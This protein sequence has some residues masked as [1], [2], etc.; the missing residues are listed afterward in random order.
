MN[1]SPTSRWYFLLLLPVW[2]ILFAGC[3]PGSS[4]AT[5]HTAAI[6]PTATPALSTATAVPE[7]NTPTPEPAPI[8]IAAVPNIRFEPGMYIAYDRKIPEANDTDTALGSH[9]FI[10]WRNIEDTPR[11][12]YNWGTIDGRLA[13]LAPGKQAIVRVVTRC[14]DTAEKNRDACAPLWTLRHNPVPVTLG[15]NSCTAPAQRMNYLDSPVQEGLFDFIAAFG[16]RYQNDPRIAVVE[17]GIGYGGE[18]IPYPATDS[19]CDHKEQQAAYEN[20]PEFTEKAW[21]QYHQD[22]ID[23]YVTAFGGKKPLLTI[24]NASF[25]EDYRDVVVKHAVDNGVGLLTTNLHS[26]FFNNRGSSNG[27]NLCYWG[28]ST[29]PG[30]SN[31]S[32]DAAA[33][34][35]THWTPLFVNAQSVLVGYEF[36]NRYDKSGRIPKEGEAF[37]RW[38]MLNGLDKRADYILPYNDADNTPGNVRY[39]EVWEFYNRYAGHTTSSTS[40]VWI[41]FRSSWEND[42]TWCPDIYDYSWYLVSELETLPYVE[43]KDQANVNDIDKNTRIYDIGDSADWRGLYARTTAD[44]WPVFNLDIDD[45]FMHDGHFDVD[46]VVT[47]F[48]HQSGGAWS[49]LYDGIGGKQSAGTVSLEGT[50]Q[51]REH[52]FHIGDA[53]FANGLE[54]YHDQSRADGFDLRIDRHDTINDIFHMVQVIPR[55]PTPTPTLTP[56]PT[57]TLTPTSTPTP[58]VTLTPTSTPTPT[59]TLTP[60]PTATATHTPTVTATRTPTPTKKPIPTRTPTITPTTTPTEVV[61]APTYLTSVTVGTHPKGVIAGPEGAQV[62]LYDSAE[63]ALVGGGRIRALID[64]NGRGA[65]AV[66]YWRGLSYMVHR[67][68]NTVSVI[69]LSTQQQVDTLEVG[70]MPWGADADANRLYVSSFGD[71]AINVFDLT[72]RQP[73]AMLSVKRQPVLVVA[74]SDRAFV[75]HLNGYI[76]VISTTGTLLDTF[77]PVAGGDA[78]GIAL[79][80]TRNH[81]YVGSRNAK[82][83]LV[84]DSQT[85]DELT[86]YQ[87]HVQ[88]FALAF[89]PDTAQLIVVDAVNDRMLAIDTGT[90]DQ[91]GA[92]SLSTQSPDHGGQGLAIWNST[93][94]VAAYA[95]GIL[96][97]F[98]GGKCVVSTSTPTTTPS[99]TPSATPTPTPSATATRTPLPSPTVTPTPAN[100]RTIT[101]GVDTY[102]DDWLPGTNFG[103]NRQLLLRTPDL[104]YTLLNFDLSALPAGA[105]VQNA[106]LYLHVL[107]ETLPQNI[108]VKAY[109]LLR[110][111]NADTANWTKATSGE[112]WSAPGASGAEDRASASASVWLPPGGS[113]SLGVTDVVRDWLAEPNSQHGIL[114]AARS[115]AGISIHLASFEHDIDEWRPQ[116]E[117]VLSP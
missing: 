36:N 62:G 35:H 111:W 49:L 71:N 100:W 91:I 47:Y 40:D 104:A 108:V 58:T 43:V 14:Q 15:D 54:S 81:L 77:G 25:A 27:G 21:V 33:A 96:D 39:N 53:R 106:Q 8:G 11:G 107:D 22:V 69:D 113:F 2:L 19:V 67:N 34:Y 68:S 114:L 101:N 9:F 5:A 115:E 70:S 31:E 103:D 41:T 109:P 64:T 110:N 57:V 48:D 83:I 79:D 116:L 63:L 28:Y 51:W 46:V 85:G 89:N 93:I 80:E 30:F 99:P 88:P 117:I 97:I 82:S 10:A 55:P 13:A 86:R 42:D 24:T 75:S 20:V 87:L 95:A 44:S 94:Y 4:S 105:Q 72:T 98:D 18:P 52:T 102:I 65:N 37:T 50:N 12:H 16:E 6:Q 29:A 38:A 84:L 92:Y 45:A 90:G 32:P 1:P 78:F 74:G 112:L 23:A 60:T 17:I 56:T 59:A 26:D 3:G 7:A 76:S 61:C 66:A 73:I